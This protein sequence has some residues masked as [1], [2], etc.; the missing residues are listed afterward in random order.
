MKTICVTLVTLG[1]SLSIA[2][3]QV[4]SGRM[5]GNITDSQG[6]SV[7]GASVK[8]SNTETRQQFDTVSDEH[9][10]WALP[11]L[12]TATYT[13]TVSHAGFKTATMENVKIDAGVPATVNTPLEVGQLTETVEVTA[14]AEVLQ[15]ATATITST[16]VG[17]QLHE[18]P[19]TSRNLTELIVTQPGSATPGVPRSTSVYGL[20]QSALNV[21]LDGLNIQDNS[22][23][24]S[25]GFFNSIFPRA[26]AVEEMTITS[27]AA[28]AESNAEGALQMKLVT[29]SG[30]NTWHGG[31]FEQHRNQYFNANYYY[32]NINN[33]PRDHIVFNQF[34]GTIG[35]PI[36]RNKLFFFANPEIFQ[37]PQTYTEPVGTVLT[38]EAAQGIFRWGDN[39][40]VFQQRNLYTLAQQAGFPSTPDP[41]IAKTLGQIATLTN[42]AAGLV[43]RISTNSDYNRKNLNF[44]SKGGNYRRFYT[45]KLDYNVT[46]KHHLAYTYTYQT[47]VRRPDGVNIGTASPIFPGTQNVLNGTE[48]GNQGG[49]AFHT[50][51]N[52]R[53]TLTNHLTSE[54]LFGLTGGTVVFNNGINTSDFAQ[55]NGF[56]PNFNFVTS[57]FRTTGQ[58]RRNTPLK[59]GNANFVWASGTHLFNFGGSFTQINIWTSASNGTQFVPGI[60]FGVASGDPIITGATN[61]FTAANF[62]GA[63]TTDYQTNAPALYALL[64]GRVSAINRSVV[65]DDET[66][67]Y[68]NVQPIVRNRQ[69]EFGFYLQDSWRVSSHL[70]VNYGTRIERQGA[71]VN[72]NSIYT[73]PGYEGVWGVSGV[74]NLFAPGVLQGSAPKFTLA[75]E[76][77]TGYQPGVQLAPSIG[78]A[79]V[80]PKTEFAPLAFLIGRSGQSVIRAGYS[81]STIREDASTYAI[82][83]GNQG[84]TFSLNID[85]TNTP[86]DFGSAGSVLFRN[87]LPAKAAPTTPNFPLAAV[88]PNSVN[89]FDPGLRVGYAQSWT[90]SLQRELTRDTVL[91]VRYVGNHGTRL[92]RILNMNEVNIFNNGFLSE[93]KIAQANKGISLATTPIL[94]TAFA[95][96]LDATANTQ[97]TQGQAGALASSIATNTTRM[98]RLTAANYPVNLFQVNPTLG[99]G[100]A[101]L[102]TNGGDTNYH[103]LQ[104]EVRRRLSK[105]LLVQ[106]SYTWAHS[107]SN[108]FSNGVAGSFTTLRDVSIDKGPSPYDIR[109]AVKLNWIYELPIGPNRYFFSSVHNPIARKALEGWQLASVTRV[110]S[111]A[112]VR[113][114]SGRAT[115]NGADS[116]V[117]LHGITAKELQDMM[118]LRKTTQVV[119]GVPQGVVYFLPDSLINNTL[120]A[121]EVGGKTL[122][123]LDPNQPYIGPANTP[124][125][126]GDRLFLYGPR[127]QKWDVSLVKKTRIR[128]RANIEFRAQALN[129]FNLTNFLLFTPGNNIPGAQGIGSAFGQIPNN[130][131]YRDLANTNDPGARILEFGLR[132]NF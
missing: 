59:Q 38:P 54:I 113:F 79:W 5:E 132:F 9:G 53:S 2:S 20:P 31:L 117:V 123:N 37:L 104:V 121:F 62:P 118:S 35:G 92:W 29:R 82:W 58:T 120:A 25:D 12:P 114:T 50:V 51:A 26:D 87:P 23:R 42:G 60:T 56:A 57:P 34:G 45:A 77:A 83:A 112:P 11:A 126:L 81:L 94:W 22:N 115:Y 43:N 28:G 131:A 8:V 93:F 16:L 101:N 18:L 128:E 4:I 49:I 85:P 122:A 74:G 72:L 103:G 86:A 109:H 48:P 119:N 71:P 17:R 91:E 95:G 99:S 116:G 73:R 39:K 97:L 21:T 32:N 64:T 84:R 52:L 108:E 105:G 106:G 13:V 76:G 68:G 46:S 55:W 75:P 88:A 110:N 44:Q 107:I 19:F 102:L 3:A 124:G 41:I 89:E 69:R 47:N 1:L 129:V 100:A 27:A 6:A 30:T 66:R 78:L 127:Q 98:N 61:L 70:T 67:I 15:T 130:G 96:A 90:L 65:L 111:G 7:P 36:I 24:S 63:T 10:H 40:G 125:V 80:T 14:G 33:Q